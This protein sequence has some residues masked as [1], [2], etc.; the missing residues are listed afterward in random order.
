RKGQP[1]AE[2]ISVPLLLRWP[3]GLPVGVAAD[4]VAGSVDVAPTLLGLCG[5]PEP[6]GTQG[7]DL[8]P[9]LRRGGVGAPAE[10]STVGAQFIAPGGEPPDA[11]YI[12]GQI[13]G[14]LEWRAVR[15]RR[16]LLAA[17]LAGEPTRLHDL[18]DDPYELRNL[19]GAAE[20]AATEAR[21]LERLRALA[22]R[23]GDPYFPS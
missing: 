11:A 4:V 9:W 6:K 8:S 22:A 3:E 1:L 5:A 21:L 12:E 16:H 7:H 14:P 18:V 10:P 20:A 23:T 13:G 15:M 19:A 17:N 2:S